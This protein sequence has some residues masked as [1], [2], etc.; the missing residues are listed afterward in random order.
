MQRYIALAVAG[1]VSWTV[2][3]PDFPSLEITGF[4]LHIVLWKARREIS[5]RAVMLKS[6]GIE[7]PSPM[8]VSAL[9]SA[10]RFKDAL[11]FI[12]A[13]P[14]WQELQDGI[15]LRSGEAAGR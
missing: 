15:V 10:P 5:R 7:M 14:G 11:P 12:I 6:L 8:A 3:F 9:V 13:I 4:R 2:I 1:P